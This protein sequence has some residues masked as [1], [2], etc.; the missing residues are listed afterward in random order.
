MIDATSY[1]QGVTSKKK[2]LS[3][4]CNG[5]DSRFLVFHHSTNDFYLAIGL[6]LFLRYC[7]QFSATFYFAV[8]A[9]AYFPRRIIQHKTK[10][11]PQ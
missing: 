6:R 5:S 4:P 2:R 3:L 8:S 1:Q 7:F 10:E 11:S 9:E